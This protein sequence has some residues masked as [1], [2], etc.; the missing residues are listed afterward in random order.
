MGTEERVVAVLPVEHLV[1]KDKAAFAARVRALGLTAYGS[2]REEA[3]GKVKQMFA[4]LVTMHREQGTLT[5]V[6][7]KSGVDWCWESELDG[8][9]PF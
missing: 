3:T 1:R 8:K 6:L 5:D 4:A 7:D 2:D 9:K